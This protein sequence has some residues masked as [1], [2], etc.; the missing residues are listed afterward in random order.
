MKKIIKFIRSFPKPT[1]NRRV[2]IAYLVFLSLFVIPVV[3]YSLKPDGSRTEEEMAVSG[4]VEEVGKLIDLPNE[5]PK[6][7]TVFEADKLRSQPFFA[8]A[9]DHDQVLL[10]EKAK[11]AILYR[12]SASK[13]VEVAIYN[14]TDKA[15]AL[16][17]GQVAG[18]AVSPTPVVPT[19]TL[20]FS[21]SDLQKKS[22]P[23][24]VIT[25]TLVSPSP[26]PVSTQP[27]ASPTPAQ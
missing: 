26:T 15:I 21:L 1:R 9:Q 3:V 4:L 20:G 24:P 13:L 2:F 23:T 6:V 27:A 10:F 5:T 22:T 7:I 25:K 11:K 14:P 12:P 16:P 8:K 19:P 18:V 17:T